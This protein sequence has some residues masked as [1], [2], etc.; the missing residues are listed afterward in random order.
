M[1]AECCAAC[2]GHDP[3]GT[4]SGSLI[5]VYEYVDPMQNPLSDKSRQLTLALLAAP[6]HDGSKRFVK[7]LRRLSQ[8]ELRH[9]MAL[10]EPLTQLTPL[11]MATIIGQT[12]AGLPHLG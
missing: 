5:N 2:I 3:S 8:Q 7:Q 10:K 11:M 4:A 6:L 1:V 9:Y 12:D